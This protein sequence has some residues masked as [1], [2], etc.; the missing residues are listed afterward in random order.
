M[1]TGQLSYIPPDDVYSI[2]R[3]HMFDDDLQTRPLTKT[4]KG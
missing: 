4:W 1:I 3:A 2:F